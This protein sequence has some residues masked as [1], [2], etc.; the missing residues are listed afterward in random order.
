MKL[1]LAAYVLPGVVM[2]AAI[3]MALGIVPPNR[4]YGFRTPKTRSSPE[5]WYPANRFAGWSLLLSGLAAFCFNLIFWSAHRDWPD[6]ELFTWMSSVSGA[7]VG[8]GAA[9][10]FLYL[11][12]L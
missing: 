7:F 8:L 10:S 11:L 5:I 6:A 1:Y 2:L 12:R 3:P 9:A 4:F